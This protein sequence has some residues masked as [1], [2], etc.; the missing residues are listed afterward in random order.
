MQQFN[1]TSSIL[2]LLASRKSASAKA[3]G[4][5]ERASD[6]DDGSDDEDTEKNGS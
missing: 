1:D 6:D 3:M 5:P 4:A 2:A